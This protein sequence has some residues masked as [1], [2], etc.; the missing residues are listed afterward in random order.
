[1]A[2]L[3]AIL[4]RIISANTVLRNN[5]DYANSVTRWSDDRSL[6]N[7]QVFGCQH[8]TKIVVRHF[9]LDFGFIASLYVHD[10]SEPGELIIRRDRPKNICQTFWRFLQLVETHSDFGGLTILVRLDEDVRPRAF[11]CSAEIYF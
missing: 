10:F 9:R 6:S 5:L 3:K 8:Q 1:M 11:H 2:A 7:A 4:L